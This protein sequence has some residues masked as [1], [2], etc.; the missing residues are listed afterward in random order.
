MFDHPMNLHYSQT[1]MMKQRPEVR[2]DHPMNLH[3]SQTVPIPTAIM[4]SLTIL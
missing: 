3:Y 1:Q 4:K 2:F